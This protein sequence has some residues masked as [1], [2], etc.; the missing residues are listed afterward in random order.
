MVSGI[1]FLA[2]AVKVVRSHHERWDGTGYAAGL[3]GA[4]IPL[5]D[6]LA[7]DTA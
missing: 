3:T 4:E 7:D 2:D 1:E 6:G 5:A